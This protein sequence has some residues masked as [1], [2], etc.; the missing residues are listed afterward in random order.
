MTADLVLDDTRMHDI[1]RERTKLPDAVWEECAMHDIYFS[2]EKAIEYG[3][4]DEIGE[5]APPPE[6]TLLHALAEPA[7]R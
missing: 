4:A 6:T 3:F 2:G 5:F 1:F 7:Q